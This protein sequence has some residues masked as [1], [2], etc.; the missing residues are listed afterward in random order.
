[1][2]RTDATSTVLE[3]QYQAAKRLYTAHG[4]DAELDIRPHSNLPRWATTAARRG[5]WRVA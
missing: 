4:S 5:I 2:D 3:Q 1:M